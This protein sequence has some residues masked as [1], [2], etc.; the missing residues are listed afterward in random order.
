MTQRKLPI[1]IQS[2]QEIRA[3]GYAYVDKTPYIASLVREGKYY[4]LSRPRRFGKSLFID[5]LD[6]AFSGRSDLFTGLY[7][8]SVESGWDF[9]NTYPV[10]RIDFAGGTLRSSSDLTNRLH[11][12]LDNWENKYSLGP[13]NGSPGDRLLPLIPHISKKTITGRYTC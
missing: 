1:G 2:F 10:L 11:R 8:H 13:S 4:F 9:S 6:C 12:I 7:L 5:T 3:G